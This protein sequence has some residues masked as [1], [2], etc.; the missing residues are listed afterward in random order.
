MTAAPDELVVCSLEAWDQIWRRNQLIVDR[1]L[2]RNPRLRVLFVEPPHDLMSGSRDRRLPPRHRLR[3]LGHEGRL[4]AFTPVKSLPRSLGTA[5]DR[6]LC[7]QIRRAAHRVG[8][9]RPVVWIND[10]SYAALLETTEWPSLY[11]ITDDWLLEPV[12]ERELH[13]RQ[14]LDA[15]LLE[16][17]GEVV[18][19]SPA[20]A[21][22]RGATRTV[23]LIP[24][25]V[26]VAHF[27]A[28]RTRPADLPPGPVAV[29][30]GTLHDERIDVDLVVDLA[31]QLHGLAITLVGPDALSPPSRSRLD[32]AGVH[33]LGPRPYDDVPAYL[34]H[35]DL[36]IVPHVLTPFTESL[37]PIKAY[38]CLAVGRPVV[39]TEVAGFRDLGGPVTAVPADR[40]VAEVAA[41]LE[42]PLSMDGGTLPAIDWDDRVDAFEG[43][44][45]RAVVRRRRSDGVGQ[46]HQADPR[47]NP[48][49]P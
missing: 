17:A 26:D 9:A 10:L 47:R 40:F 49:E 21:A 37:D 24:N 3:D 20:L 6:A 18:V 22:S 8:M 35:A 7:W 39:A 15:Q 36:V 38:E 27:T 45:A 30:V 41:R 34:Q 44:L 19:C 42:T 5:A 16:E 48:D 28:P 31:A 23:T 12:S 4:S 13:R 11:D 32:A 25:G 14:R 1:L 2:Q 43:V 33:R 46:D 29:Y